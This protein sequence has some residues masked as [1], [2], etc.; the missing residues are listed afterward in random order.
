MS[1]KVLSASRPANRPELIATR[2]RNGRR[3]DL[4]LLDIDL[5][6]DPPRSCPSRPE[7]PLREV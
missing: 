1:Q 6:T 4:T 7:H 2:Q 3:Y 5:N